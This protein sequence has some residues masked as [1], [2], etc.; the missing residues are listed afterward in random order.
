M[1]FNDIEK[2]SVNNIRIL[3]AEMVQKANSGHPGM[4][5]GCSDLVFTIWYHY[6][7]YDYK[8]PN[9]VGRD[10]F[11]LSAGHCSALY[12]VILYLFGCGITLEDL[13]KFR[14]ID[15]ITTG[16]P[17]YGVTDH[18][19]VSTGL[20]GS[21]FSTA[22]GMA[23][24]SKSFV[25]RAGLNNTDLFNDRK[26]YIVCGDGCIMEGCVHE[27]ASLAGHLGL[28]NI[29]CIYDSNNI[30]AES[31]INLISSEDVA[32]RFNA[33][34]WRVIIVDDANDIDKVKIGMDLAIKNDTRPTILI[35]NTQPAFGSPNKCGMVS[36]HGSALGQDEILSIKKNLNFPN[37]EDDFFV[38]SD[39]LDSCRNKSIEKEKLAGQWNEKLNDF[40][41]KNKTSKKLIFNLT[42]RKV[43]N[44][45]IDKLNIYKNNIDTDISDD[46]STRRLN[47][48]I[49]QNISDLV[50]S[51]IGGSADLATS[52]L[53]SIDNETSFLKDNNIGRN[54]HFGVRELC[55]GFAVNGMS[56]HG[57]CISY[58]STFLVFS[59]YMKPAIRMAALQEIPV[60]Y[61]FTHD[62]MYVGE[63]G[64]THHPIE[65]L[66]MLRSIP[67]LLVIRP[68]DI[69]EINQAWNIMLN[70]KGPSALI[71]TRQNIK[72]EFY[73][74]K[75]ETVLAKGA[76]IYLREEQD[77][78]CFTIIATGSEVVLASQVAIMLR[79]IGYSTRVVSMPSW[80]LFEKQ[81]DEYKD[82][83]IPK[84][85]KKISIEIASKFGWER[86]I[87]EDGL[88]IGIDDFGVSAPK[89][90]LEKRYGF[91]K[92]AI[93]DRIINTL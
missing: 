85:S 59:D 25:Y 58:C 42:E 43:P 90:H 82:Y 61:I 83:I 89:E 63:D 15:S 67:K 38:I 16:H 36:T 12:Y 39:V 66:I 92:D 8:N 64:P 6:M 14:Q 26:I 84:N 71:L 4:A 62:S 34:G 60:I 11:I 22:V 19:E 29:I 7:R 3:I 35:G 54:I 47:G 46:I 79:K 31:N 81:S 80:E 17:E 87:G 76:Y 48:M 53:T 23:I 55:M 33:Y 49:M 56:L 52:T 10:R 37:I 9:W 28:N 77:D 50:P 74:I 2:L 73:T 72:N 27:S 1:R 30:S 93:F 45:L 44:N 78:L 5:M 41:N 51:L 32:K 40:M 91:S 18:V 65:H 88:S 68:V 69:D 20:L 24:A 70:Y 86:F 57:T 21:G 13:K 75:N